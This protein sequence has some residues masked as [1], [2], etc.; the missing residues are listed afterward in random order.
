MKRYHITIKGNV[1][2]VGFRRYASQI[3]RQ[4]GLKGKATYIDH[5]ITIEVEGAVESLKQFMQW[6]KTGPNGCQ[7]EDII[8]TEYPLYGDNTFEIVPGVYRSGSFMEC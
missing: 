7:V 8:L 5:N 2:R 1:Q 4:L 6:C 3:A